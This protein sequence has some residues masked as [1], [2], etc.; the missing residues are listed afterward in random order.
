MQQD[1]DS[2]TSIYGSD[3]PFKKILLAE[4]AAPSAA[5]PFL[6]AVSDI[7]QQS[8]AQEAKEQAPENQQ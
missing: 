8:R 7:T 6:Q 4:A 5:A 2:T 1:A 3:V